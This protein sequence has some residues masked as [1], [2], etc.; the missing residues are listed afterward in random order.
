MLEKQFLLFCTLLFLQTN[1]VAQYCG[2]RIDS[3]Y[4]EV[5]PQETTQYDLSRNNQKIDV[6]VVF[7]R[8]LPSDDLRIVE[9]EDLQNSIEEVIVLLKI[10]TLVS[11]CVRLL[12]MYIMINKSITK[13]REHYI[14]CIE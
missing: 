11:L 4:A 14:Y 10:V 9:I 12:I 8:V 6:P 3:S 13:M 1:L 2:T 7:H 5:H